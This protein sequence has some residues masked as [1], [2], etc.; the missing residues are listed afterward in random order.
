M[1]ACSTCPQDA[2]RLESAKAA[3]AAGAAGALASLP[4]VASDGGGGAAAAVLALATAGVASALLGVT[5]RYAVCQ[6][7]AN[8]Q[9]KVRGG[10]VFWRGR[11]WV[12]MAAH[13]WWRWRSLPAERS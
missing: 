8:T 3:A 11:L 1:H 4:L 5:Y 9:L 6:D 10:C 13:G 7:L 2:E 12:W